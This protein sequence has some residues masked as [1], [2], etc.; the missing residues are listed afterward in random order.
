MAHVDYEPLA[1]LVQ[2]TYRRLVRTSA[3]ERVA[4]DEEQAKQTQKTKNALEDAGNLTA[5]Q[6]IEANFKSLLPQTKRHVPP[7]QPGGNQS[8]RAT[9]TRRKKT[10]RR[11]KARARAHPRAALPRRPMTWARAKEKTKRKAKGKAMVLESKSVQTAATKAKARVLHP[12]RNYGGTRSPSPRM[13][14]GGCCLAASWF[15]G[16]VCR[17]T[18]C[19]TR[20]MLPAVYHY[21]TEF[22]GHYSFFLEH[23]PANIFS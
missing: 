22:R 21:T 13:F 11:A 6:V 20:H 17:P 2:A 9:A 8:R 16:T 15:A 7:G 1:E 10:S 5:N 14:S 19:M 3:L 18:R 23:T 12:Q 4:I